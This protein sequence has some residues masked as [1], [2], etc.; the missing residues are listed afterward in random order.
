MNSA[1]V[2]PEYRAILLRYLAEEQKLIIDT[3]KHFRENDSKTDYEIKA[4]QFT[5]LNR[6][7]MQAVKAMLKHIQFPRNSYIG[8]DG[9]EAMSV[10]ALHSKAKGLELVF[11]SFS[12]SLKKHPK[13]TE[14][15]LIPAMEDR[16][17]I[18]NRSKQLYVKVPKSR[19]PCLRLFR[20]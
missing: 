11:N 9:A 14:K 12:L 8:K 5:R 7:Q 18:L 13:D 19:T 15:S 3:A 6:E 2:Y 20:A 4:Q 16:L 17:L 1:V 10:I